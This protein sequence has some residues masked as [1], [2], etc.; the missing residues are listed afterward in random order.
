MPNWCSNS[1]QVD[2]NSKDINRL[3]WTNNGLLLNP[4]IPTPS[5]LNPQQRY[6]WCLKHWGV[7][8]DATITIS[9]QEDDYL[10]LHF[11]TPWTAP[12]AGISTIALLFPNLD[13]SLDSSE[14]GCDWRAAF[15]WQQGELVEE[16]NGTYYQQSP[17]I[18]P[19]CKS[20]YHPEIDL[21]GSIIY[22]ECFECGWTD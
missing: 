9:A 8:W 18:C 11:D 15:Y 5:Y 4:I 19:K 12:V 16:V 6:H 13:F 22:S 21:G 7:K 3:P 14:P 2:G 1:L 17:L 10:H 20:P